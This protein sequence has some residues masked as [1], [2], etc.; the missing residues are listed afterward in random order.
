MP[1]CLLIVKEPWTYS[2]CY[3]NTP[4]TYK[5]RPIDITMIERVFGKEVL[6]SR[7][8]NNTFAE[9]FTKEPDGKCLVS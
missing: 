5:G 9:N 3:N 6:N 8:L 2:I 7:M 1:N 4:M